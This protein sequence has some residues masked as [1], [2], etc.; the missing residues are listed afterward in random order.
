[1]SNLLSEKICI[2]CND[3]LNKISLAKRV[4]VENQLKLMKM[5]EKNTERNSADPLIK[6]EIVDFPVVKQEPIDTSCHVVKGEEESQQE[7]ETEH[8]ENFTVQAIE[9]I[10]DKASPSTSKPKPKK[11]TAKPCDVPN[12]LFCP[13]CDKLYTRKSILRHHIAAVHLKTLRYNCNMDGCEYACYQKGNLTIHQRNVHNVPGTKTYFCE[14]CG[15][16]Y[17]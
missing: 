7:M 4:L 5:L 1:M 3:E 12:D 6:L 15:A 8:T 11:P 2:V 16:E 17:K 9:Q 14:T 10:R 13:H